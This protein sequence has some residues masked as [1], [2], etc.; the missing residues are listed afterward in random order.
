MVSERMGR[1][2]K[3]VDE[4]QGEPVSVRL[5][6]EVLAAIRRATAVT[7]IAQST[8]IR[9]AVLEKLYRDGFWKPPK[10]EK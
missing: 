3:T 6:T 5:Q 10:E 9:A 1:G 8:Y 4:Q 2:R 7:Q